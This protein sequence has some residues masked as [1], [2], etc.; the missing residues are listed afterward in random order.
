MIRRRFFPRALL[1]AAH[2]AINV[3]VG[4]VTKKEFYHE[5]Y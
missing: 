1:N 2:L 4:G 5:V 3:G